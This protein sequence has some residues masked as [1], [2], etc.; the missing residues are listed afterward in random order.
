MSDSEALD[1]ADSK[2]LD[3]M[4]IDSMHEATAQFLQEHRKEI[5]ERAKQIMQAKVA[6][7]R[8]LPGA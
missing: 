6:K 3:K 2:L 1:A 4:L 5:V 7:L 8:E